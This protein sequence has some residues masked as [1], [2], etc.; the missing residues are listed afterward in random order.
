MI[1]LCGPPTGIVLVLIYAMYIVPIIVF[2]L[3]VKYSYK[4]ASF[5]HDEKNDKKKYEL[6]K[7][8]KKLNK[9]LD[10]T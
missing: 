1:N 7:K 5:K 2:Y 6:E 10:S 8:L 3:A 9:A 4:L